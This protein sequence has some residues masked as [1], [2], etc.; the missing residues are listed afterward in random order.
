MGEPETLPTITDAEIRA[1][2][3]KKES[4]ELSLRRKIAA[5]EKEVEEL[6]RKLREPVILSRR[7]DS[8]RSSEE[9]LSK[10][11]AGDAIVLGRRKGI[12]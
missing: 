4:I 12:L 11:S 7:A 5:L 3:K 6:K 8:T 10:I 1:R 2:G 9:E